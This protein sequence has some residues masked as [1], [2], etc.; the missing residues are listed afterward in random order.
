M[1]VWEQE[2]LSG[3]TV[4]TVILIPDCIDRLKI[5]VDTFS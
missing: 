4:L 3:G 1:A 5:G 2:I